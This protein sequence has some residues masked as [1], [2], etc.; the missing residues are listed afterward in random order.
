M[1]SGVNVVIAANPPGVST[2]WNSARAAGWSKKWN[3]DVDTT[4]SSAPSS[5]GNFSAGANCQL[6]SDERAFA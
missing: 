3:A 5:N 1:R 4:A 6:T 2:R